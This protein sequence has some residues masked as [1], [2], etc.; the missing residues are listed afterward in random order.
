MDKT[1]CVAII[2][3]K[4]ISERFPGKN[5]ALFL[6]VPLWRLAANVAAG[7]GVFSE[8]IISTDDPTIFNEAS[9]VCSRIMRPPILSA[10]GVGV[11]AVVFHVLSTLP[12]FPKSF[13]VVLP[14]SPL[15]KVGH[16]VAMWEKFSKSSQQALL[17]VRLVPKPHEYFLEMRTGYV[18]RIDPP[19]WRQWW[20]HD[21]TALFC[22]TRAFLQH[23]DFYKIP[24]DAFPIPQEES[25]DVNTE[26]D[27]VWAEFLAVREAERV[28]L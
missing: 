11:Q 20:I 5:K 4:G 12:E 1:P 3:A 10:E 28:Q 9:G 17:S 8:V 14:T 27:L 22:E 18:D 23:F 24:M 7:S 13:C 16:L 26:Q 25:V 2:P 21:G 6:G 15:R 19:E